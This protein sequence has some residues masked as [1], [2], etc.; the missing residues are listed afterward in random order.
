MKKRAVIVLVSCLL[1]VGCG[2]KE[3]TYQE[4]LQEGFEAGYEECLWDYE[5]C[6]ADE[7]KIVVFGKDYW[8]NKGYHDGSIGV[9]N[10]LDEHKKFKNETLQAIYEEYY[11]QGFSDGVAQKD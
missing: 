3:P 4:G 7:G 2:S 1:L 8:Y 9:A 10:E 6:V 11:A 5:N